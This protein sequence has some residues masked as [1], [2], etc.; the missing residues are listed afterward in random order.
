M[1]FLAFLSR[2][3]E[4]RMDT[5]TFLWDPFSS[6]ID[7]NQKRAFG[8]TGPIMSQWQSLGVKNT[9]CSFLSAPLGL[10]EEWHMPWWTGKGLACLPNAGQVV[11]YW[12]ELCFSSEVHF[13]H[14]TL[15]FWVIAVQASLGHKRPSN[16]RHS[17]KPFGYFF[18]SF[19]LFSSTF[20][21]N[22]NN[23]KH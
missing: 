12:S 6:P 1:L 20:S 23:D 10:N 14:P 2:T 13:F 16:L 11:C 5:D 8:Q 21:Q 3:R 4:H 15:F 9:L 18:R 19:S 17:H 7:G 22:H